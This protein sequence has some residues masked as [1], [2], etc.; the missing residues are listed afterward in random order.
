MILIFIRYLLQLDLKLN[1][2]AGK[3]EKET[4]ALFPVS[5]A[6]FGLK[7]FWIVFLLGNLSYA[8]NT[9]AFVPLTEKDT[10]QE[11][12]NEQLTNVQKEIAKQKKS[13]IKVNQKR[14]NLEKELKAD[15]LAI[16]KVAKAINLTHKE[17]QITKKKIS[18]LFKKKAKLS[19]E[20]KQQEKILARQLRAAYSSGQ[21]DYLK[22]LLSQKDPATVER[23]STYYKYL[24]A[25][26]MKEIDNFQATIASLLLITTEHQ[27]QVT[28]LENL[29]QNQKSQKKHLQKNKTLRAQTIKLLNKEL[30]TNKQQ[31]AKLEA[32]ENNLVKELQKLIEIAKA[33]TEID[34]NG[35]A[36]LKKKL[37]WPVKGKISHSYGSKKQ[38]YLKWKGVLL[39][40]PVGRQVITIH[41]GKVLFADWLKGY[42]LVTVIDHG[43]GYMSLYAHNQALLKG[44]GDRVETGEPIAL[45]GQSGGQ[46]KP[47]LYFEIRHKGKAKNPKLWCK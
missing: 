1:L 19:G 20:K 9:A 4:R 40:A 37:A 45:V 30:L 12:T 5:P 6:K 16:A 39:S 18:Q 34:L 3:H 32:Q 29:K 35:L 42:G 22:L 7:S 31:L 2:A 27:E 25:A 38:G 11:S 46:Q 13:I 44:V 41:N 24:N 23:T 26:R 21:H 10:N 43:N 14:D 33:K 36:K 28:R 8:A 15:D 47:G 17:H